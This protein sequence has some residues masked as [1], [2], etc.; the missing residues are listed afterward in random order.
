M[1]MEMERELISVPCAVVLR[2]DHQTLALLGPPVDRLDNVDELLLILQHPV[3]LVVVARAEIAHHVLV[4]EKEH[5]GAGV[6]QLVHAVEVGHLWE[7]ASEN[8]ASHSHRKSVEREKGG[9][10][11]VDVAEVDDG[12]VL[13]SVGYLVENFILTHAG[14]CMFVSWVVWKWGGKGMGERRGRAGG[15]SSYR[16]V[17]TP[18]PD[19]DEAIFLCSGRE[20]VRLERER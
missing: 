13:H 19:D 6:V 4:A 5:D 15:V 18:E 7:G 12:K 11:L 20:S 8:A 14:L 3:E 2:A 10:Y 17:V 9:T 1:E 16:I